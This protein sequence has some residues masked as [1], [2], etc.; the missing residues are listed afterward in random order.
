MEKCSIPGC[1]NGRPEEE[2]LCD[3]HMDE[4]WLEEYN[5]Y[6]TLREEGMDRSE[7]IEKSG[8]GTANTR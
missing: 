3:K 6:A 8:L 4:G 2:K 7:A 5:L 1:C